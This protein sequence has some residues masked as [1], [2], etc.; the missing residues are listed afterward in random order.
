M[1]YKAR[2]KK[3][4]TYWWDEDRC[5]SCLFSANSDEEARN[6]IATAVQRMNRTYWRMEEPRNVSIL[7]LWQLKEEG[8]SVMRREV[9]LQCMV[10]FQKF[11]DIR[12]VLEAFYPK[13][14]GNAKRFSIVGFFSTWKPS[15]R[16][17]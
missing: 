17:H 8:F 11:K 6:F 2:L 5:E 4:K 16:F 12:R 13:V 7:K 3:E 14:Y 15:P 1:M 9:C 10:P